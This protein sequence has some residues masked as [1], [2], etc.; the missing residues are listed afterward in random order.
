MFTPTPWGGPSWKR[1]YARRGALERI[2]A[3]LDNSFA[4]ERHFVR[5][6]A[7]MR[8]RMGLGLGLA[9]ALAVMMALALGSVAAGRRARMSGTRR[10]TYHRRSGRRNTDVIMTKDT[11]IAAMWLVANLL[12]AIVV[13]LPTANLLGGDYV[14]ALVAPALA[15]AATFGFVFAFGR[16]RQRWPAP[17]YQGLCNLLAVLRPTR[18]P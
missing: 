5:G 9:L 3:R 4:F 1:G 6:R 7:K 10:P 18:S 11:K 15:M 13:Y 16:N 14:M 12:G 8:A 17:I 2:N